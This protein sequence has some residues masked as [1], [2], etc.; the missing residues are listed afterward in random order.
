MRNCAYL[1]LV[2]LFPAKRIVGGGALR[3]AAVLTRL[4]ERNQI[5]IRPSR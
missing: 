1:A 4:Y 3:L 5:S 2:A